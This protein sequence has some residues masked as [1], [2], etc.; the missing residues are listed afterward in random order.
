MHYHIVIAAIV[1]PL[2]LFVNHRCHKWRALR[3]ASWIDCLTYQ[4]GE[5]H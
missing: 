2:S 4:R 1:V 3:L 5:F